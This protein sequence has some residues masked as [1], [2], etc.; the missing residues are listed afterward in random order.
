MQIKKIGDL[1]RV[2]F[3]GIGGIGMSALARYFHSRGIAVSGYDKTETAL[4]KALVAEG[5]PVHYE[6]NLTLAPKDADWVVYTPAIPAGHQELDYYRAEGYAVMKRSE[7]L[8][9]ITESSFNICVAGTHGKTTT[10]TMIAHLLRDSGY[11]CNAFLGGISAN[12]NTNFWSSEKDVCV[13]EADEYDRSFLKLSPDVAVVTA[14]DPDHLDIYGTEE[15]VR[16]AF[17]DFA[18]RLKRGGLLIRKL[19]IGRELKAERMWQYSLQNDSANIYAAN[20]RIQDGGYV[21]DIVLPTQQIEGL[22]LNM[23]GMHN[24]ENMVAAVAVASSLNIDAEKI[25]AAVASFKGVKRRFEYMIKQKDLVFIDDYAHHPEELKAL[26]NSVKTL[27]PQ[28]KCTL[29]FQP[30]LYSRTKDFA[31]DFAAVLSMVNKAILLPVYPAREQPIPGIESNTIAELM[32]GGD[33]VLM[34]KEALLTWIGDDVAQ[35]REKEFGEVIV[36][37][38]AGDIDKLVGPI[39]DR[40]LK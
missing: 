28:K 12:Y 3:I 33:P 34:T 40:L 25:K 26:I 10:T 30:H 23:G 6:D 17:A 31:Q 4:T 2:Y 21:F 9:Q 38:G 36:T 37:A 35:H 13:I 32:D 14:V 20:I 8:Q 1:K 22:Q 24:I 27:F 16:Q 18:Q 29:I 7:V 5:M 15:Q 39:K 19:G 11:G